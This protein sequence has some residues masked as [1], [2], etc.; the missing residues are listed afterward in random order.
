[1]RAPSDHGVAS[2]F[3]AAKGAA[4]CP[5]CRSAMTP[6]FAVR[7]MPALCNVL[8]PSRA[9][10][11]ETPRADIELG[12]C[13]QCGMIANLSFDSQL[14]E[15]DADYE[16][17][18]H[19]SQ[20]F[21]QHAEQLV[22][23]LI[24]RY[25][26][27]GKTIVEIGCGDG[28]FLNLMCQRGENRGVGYDPSMAGKPV[29]A[30]SGTSVTIVPRLFGTQDASQPADL[31]CCRHVLEHIA[32]PLAFLSTI[33]QAIG[34]RESV[35]FL[36]V[37]NARW[38]IRELRFWDV[39]YEHCSYFTPQ[40]L[41]VLI[42]RSGFIPL[43]VAERYGDQFL[44][45]EAQPAPGNEVPT[46]DGA[47]SVSPDELDRFGGHY[48][49]TIGFWNQK[50]RELQQRGGRP[51]VW[52]AGSKGVSF[53]NALAGASNHA[54]EYVVDLNPR[55]QGKFVAGAGQAIVA[56]EALS[57]H[58]PDLVIVMNEIYLDE[59]RQSLTAMGVEAEVRAV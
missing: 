13:G 56:P 20:R 58:R 34:H 12:S 44:T 2:G 1:M 3:A 32:D 26:L 4:Q 37:P 15:Y 38:M 36:E 22:A 18:L 24:D 8:W 35:L 27:R 51:V 59:I 14:V 23:E 41:E 19:F 28:H 42:R 11:L 10:A 55:K 40:S 25:R 29:T 7:Q 9:A 53:L 52:G 46:D 48:T 45:I 30:A 43:H 17:A 54:I 39:I 6:F 33:R 31:I 57:S 5:V 47:G 16:N 50:L 21:Q 49:Q